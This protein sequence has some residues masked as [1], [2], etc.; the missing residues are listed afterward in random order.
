MLIGTLWC[1]SGVSH[2]GPDVV[3]WQHFLS[4]LTMLVALDLV[5][6][7]CRLSRRGLGRPFCLASLLGE[8]L[9]SRSNLQASS[10]GTWSV[11]LSHR[12]AWQGLGRL[13]RL[14]VLL[15]GY[16]AKKEVMGLSWV[17]YP[18]VPDT[19]IPLYYMTNILLPKS[20][21]NKLNSIIKNLWWVGIKEESTSNPITFRSWEGI[22]KP[23]SLSG[24][25]IK[26]LHIVNKSL[27]NHS[28]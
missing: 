22:C 18:Q 12:L 13:F 25:G 9:V 3:R 28:P 7:P 4:Q 2:V 21:T 24:L 15:G 17:P 16:L 6:P 14:A 5:A 11:V 19:S 23:K 27:V 26:D 1:Y 20:F 8:Y 10:A